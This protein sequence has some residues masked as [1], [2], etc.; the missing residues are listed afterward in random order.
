MSPADAKPMTATSLVTA[1]ELLRDYRGQR[2]ELIEG[3]VESMS[4][5][6]GEHG[7]LAADLVAL[8]SIHAK[9]HGLGRCFGAETGFITGRN[10]DTVLAPDVA[11]VRKQ[12]LDVI[13]VTEKYFPEAPTLAVE[14]VSPSDTAE[15]VDSKARRWLAAGAEA[16]WV[17][18]PRGKSVT[19]YKSLD[20]VRVYQSDQ[21][22]DD[23][24]L[25][26][27]FQLNI[28]ELFSGLS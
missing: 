24:E 11:F 21:V 20:D 5:S 14:I 16:V 8:L 26:P 28:A 9:Q 23:L 13:G 4:P 10:P 15:E 6:G 7:V 17:V 19:V 12:R 18:Y 22:L 27:D 1:E 25:L 2:C 3:K